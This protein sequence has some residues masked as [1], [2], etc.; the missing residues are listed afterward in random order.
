MKRIIWIGFFYMWSCCAGASDHLPQ[1][2]KQALSTHH[3]P[4]AA[5]SI[6]MQSFNSNKPLWVYQP[7]IPR[8]PASTMKL[9]TS[10]AA[11]ELL[12]PAYRWRTVLATTA[13]IKEGVLQGDLYI[14]GYGDPKLTTE[15]I[16]M[17]L[18][19][20]RDQGIQ[21]IKGDLILD[22]TW[23]KAQP[24]EPAFDATPERAYNMA[25]DALIF[26]FNAINVTAKSDK[27]QVILDMDPPLPCISLNNALKVSHDTCA[28]AELPRPL[29]A[30]MIAGGVN[31][32]FAGSFPANC[33]VSRY[34]QF[35]ASPHYVGN[36]FALTWQALGGI[37]QGRVR[38][39]ILPV[40]AKVLYT[41]YSPDLVNVI[42]DINKFSNNTMA[43]L[44]YLTLG[45]EQQ[46]S[47]S[48]SEEQ[49][50]RWLHRTGFSPASFVIENGSGLSRKARISAALLGQLIHKVMQSPYASEWESSL[51]IV[52]VDGSMKTRLDD[53]AIAGSA[54]IK[55]GS[56]DGVRAIAG[57]ITGKNGKKAVIVAILNQPDREIGT[58]VLDEVLKHAWKI[59]T[60][61]SK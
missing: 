4:A 51:P 33:L 29:I 19:A 12:G 26:N 31:V 11:L 8:S 17:L 25:P 41:H 58:E 18:K 20:L 34:Y 10:Y 22:R 5:L 48:A 52:G 59:I 24:E 40:Q 3:L 47:L 42:R 46:A 36:F 2:I 37:W 1:P 43:R 28:Q 39:G 61:P 45:A 9:I 50:L 32:Q 30:E 55:T 60:Q 13:P 27:D 49:V 44:V 35:I 56:L 54:H 21:E 38:E 53:H 14:K 7:D 23:F 57:T 15:H 6:Y 16:Y